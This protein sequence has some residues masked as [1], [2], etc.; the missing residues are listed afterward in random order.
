[1]LYNDIA[2]NGIINMIITL[3]IFRLGGFRNIHFTAIYNILSCNTKNK[4]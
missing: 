2:H 1:M 3:S 4:Q